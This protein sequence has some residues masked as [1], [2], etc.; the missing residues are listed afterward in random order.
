MTKAIPSTYFGSK[1]RVALSAGPAVLWAVERW[2]DQVGEGI[3]ESD[4]DLEASW[5]PAR[6]HHYP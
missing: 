6:S 4:H 1:G 5:H 2:R 3:P